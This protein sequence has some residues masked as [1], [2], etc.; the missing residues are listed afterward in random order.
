MRTAEADLKDKVKSLLS[1]IPNLFFWMP[2]PTGYGMRGIPDFIGCYK[3]RFFA[4]ETKAPRGKETPWQ[5]FTR[6][7]IIAA[8]GM[9]IVAWEIEDV[10][11]F[12]RQL[13]TY[14]ST[15]PEPLNE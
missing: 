12:I 5:R 14:A 7:K 11:C 4:I 2:V 13:I 6:E 10:Q 3:G 1:G 15:T 9:A 8:G